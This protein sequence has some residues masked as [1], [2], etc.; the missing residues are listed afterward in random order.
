ML[1]TPE[2]LSWRQVESLL[3]VNSGKVCCRLPYRA[4][5]RDA[6]AMDC[7]WALLGILVLPGVPCARF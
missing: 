3:E 7:G 4:V 1:R 6:V 5:G 2:S